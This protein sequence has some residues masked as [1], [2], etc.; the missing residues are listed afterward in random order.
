MSDLFERA[1]NF[2]HMRLIPTVKRMCNR[3]RLS[4][5]LLTVA[6]LFLSVLLLSLL[7]CHTA[8][9]MD[10]QAKLEAD[11]QAYLE[12]TVI[13]G[14]SAR[15]PLPEMRQILELARAECIASALFS[16]LIWLLLSVTAIG[17]IMS[18][19]IES[20][21]YVYGLYMIYGAGKKQLK[22]QL[23]VEFLLAGVLAMIPGI[24]AGFGVYAVINHSVAFPW[25]LLWFLIPCF[26]L[27]ILICSSVLAQQILSRSCMRMLNMSD[28]SE[29]TVSPRRSHLG[30]L[31]RKRGAVASAALAIW[32]MRKHYASMILTASILA[33]LICGVLSPVVPMRNHLEADYLLRFPAGIHS[34]TLDWEYIR[35]L[36]RYPAVSQMGYSITDTADRLGTHLLLDAKQNGTEGG[37]SL[38]NRYATASFRIACGDRET[39]D[40]LGG[41]VTVPEE[42]RDVPRE[43]MSDFGYVLDGVPVGCATYVYP[44]GTTPP[45]SL[46]IGDTV[47]LYL[48]N[49]DTPITERVENDADY[50]TVRIHDIVEVNSIYMERGGPE[51]C[52]RIT[53]D[54]LYLNPLDYEKFDGETHALSL[55]A[56]EALPSDLFQEEDKATCILVVPKGYFDH[57]TVPTH[58]TVISPE[59]AV[60]VAF[61]NAQ[62]KDNLPDDTYFVNLTS[63]GTGVYLGTE[64]EY[65]ADTEAKDALTTH[66]MNTLGNRIGNLFPT[67]VCHE[68]EVEQII[69]TEHNGSPY[70]ILPNRKEIN[71]SA[72]QFDVCA[73]HLSNISPKAP[74][75][76]MIFEEAFLTETDQPIGSSFFHRFY[77]I[78]TTLLPDFVHE[79][80]E[81]DLP[82]QFPEGWFAHTETEI[83]N[84]FTLNDHHYLLSE[85]Y[86]YKY[87]QG[88]LQAEE[89]P[90]VIT[91]TG[92]FIPVGNVKENSIISAED[93]GF[94]GLFSDNSIGNLKSESIEVDGLYARNDCLITPA[95]EFSPN[96]TLPQGHAIYVTADPDSSTIR[97][98]D[99]VSLAIRQDTTELLR[100]PEFMSLTGERLLAY[101]LDKLDYRYVEIMVDEVRAG[102][103]TAL[104]LSEEDLLSIMGQEGAYTDL[105]I[106]LS[107]DTGMYDYMQ[108]HAAIQKL[109]KQSKGTA[110]L[111]FNER[112]MV[113]A[114]NGQETDGK[115]LRAIGYAAM[116]LIPLILIAAQLV[117]YGK[118]SE[119]FEI[120]HAMGKTPRQRRGLFLAET[121]IFAC[122]ACICTA[123]ICPVGYLCALLLADLVKLPMTIAGLKMELYL[124]LLAIVMV[125]CLL[126]GLLAYLRIA[127]SSSSRHRPSG[128]SPANPPTPS[129]KE[130]ES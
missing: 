127:H 75:L 22:R 94:F 21:S 56:E 55:V 50:I 12:S 100:D 10:V 43:L 29:F 40:E 36:S 49:K 118:R 124:L 84:R 101:L 5:T 44:E 57:I 95:G 34:D 52:P 125:S 126:S 114:Q 86:P 15:S 73:F 109:V 18:S 74:Q 66:V 89:Y 76:R 37:I 80:K 58:V 117:F 97:P 69:Y 65:L 99:A 116:C 121:G 2:Y 33:T 13:A 113:D 81:H 119:E 54:Y 59:D 123:V 19:V 24:P 9:A 108:F 92:S 104:V 41:Q 14:G 68:Y 32:R 35:P 38:G 88:F 96:F 47:R 62:S 83:H 67:T 11:Y 60:K 20:E 64:K 82:L 70:L 129:R 85:Y 111:S 4:Y 8:T 87:N 90:R 93:F 39:Y 17:R 25:H 91:G 1:V 63:K 27:L 45:L 112:F 115:I 61:G 71:Y 31:S 106:Y 26:L 110:I 7:L 79:M 103:D 28:T 122:L 51:V 77:F 30:G 3:R 102:S 107:P 130:I 72:L 105:H 6:A 98:G 128:K 120:L 46:H 48:P 53:E 78:G 42:F 23:S 16:G